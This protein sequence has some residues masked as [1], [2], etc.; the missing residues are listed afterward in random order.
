MEMALFQRLVLA[1]AVAAHAGDACADAV[2]LQNGDRISG[3]LV[4]LSGEVLRFRGVYTNLLEIPWRDVLAVTTEE[5]VEVAVRG[6][7]PVTGRL[8]LLDGEQ[9]ITVNGAVSHVAPGEIIAIAVPGAAAAEA[10]GIPAAPDERKSAEEAASGQAAPKK[11]AGDVTMGASW[12]KGATD[13]FDA[14]TTLTVVRQ[15]PGDTLTFKSEAGYG[16]VESQKNTQ[17]ILGELKWQHFWNE[18]FYGYWLGGA[19]HDAGRQLDLRLRTGAGLGKEFINNEQ[20]K[21]SLEGGAGY[22]RE[23]WLEY[24]LLAEDAARDASKNARLARLN[25]FLNQVGTLNGLELIAAS[26]RYY[27]DAESLKFHNDTV[28][29]DSITVHASS[30]Y[31]Q[32]VFA[33]SLFSSDLTVEPDIDDFSQYRILSDLAFLTPLSEKMSLK[34][35]LYSE[36]DSHPGDVDA[37]NWEHKF[38]T[39]LDYKF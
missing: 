12:R 31:E 20:R 33:R 37:E 11:W 19:E 38:L 27:Y 16:E 34:I 15:W 4:G 1:W 30:H 23:Y 8:I 26:L 32:K 21:L 7:G 18:R 24:G 5:A 14:A 35:R 36:Y 6:S 3:S 17:R 28:T 10:A 9:A 22:R 2:Y 39:G 13:T 25:Q 29:E